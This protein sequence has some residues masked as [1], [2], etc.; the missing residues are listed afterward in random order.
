MPRHWSICARLRCI[1]HRDSN[2]D[3]GIYNIHPCFQVLL[4]SCLGAVAFA[5]A[6]VAAFL[7]GPKPVAQN[8]R[9]DGMILV[10][11]P[12]QARH[13]LHIWLTLRRAFY[14][15]QGK[16]RLLHNRKHHN[17]HVGKSRPENKLGSYARHENLERYTRT[18]EKKIA[19]CDAMHTR[20]ECENLQQA[21]QTCS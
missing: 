16:R 21:S 9:N 4:S 19:V 2:S 5:I 12:V 17:L 14:E 13:F 18:R 3:N 8:A 6:G 10:I 15:T 20:A 11:F 1:G 7:D